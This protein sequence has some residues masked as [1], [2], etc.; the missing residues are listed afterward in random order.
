MIDFVTKQAAYKSGRVHVIPMEN[1]IVVVDY[2]GDSQ[3][4]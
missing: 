1:G 3:R 2:I 4:L